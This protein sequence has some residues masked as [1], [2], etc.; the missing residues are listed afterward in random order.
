[1]SMVAMGVSKFEW[2][3]LVAVSGDGGWSVRS[4]VVVIGD[5]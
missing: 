3:L 5:W 1:M 4:V 2:C